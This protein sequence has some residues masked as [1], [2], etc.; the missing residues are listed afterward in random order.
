MNKKDMK[1][2]AKQIAQLEHRLETESL[3]Q[4]ERDE[5]ETQIEALCM[6][7]TTFQDMDELDEMIQDFLKKF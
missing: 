4:I 2:L 6:K 7:V 3:T 1:K 5:I